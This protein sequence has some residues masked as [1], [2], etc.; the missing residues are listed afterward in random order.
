LV[1]PPSVDT[2]HFSLDI[3]KDVARARLNIPAGK[4]V[5]LFVGQFIQR[6]GVSTLIS[7]LARCVNADPSI[8]LVLVGSGIEKAAY[9]NLARRIGVLDHIVFPGTV[10]Y[11]NLPLF[12][13]SADLFVLPSFQ[14]GFGVVLVEALSAGTPIV[15]SRIDGI[16]DAVREGET[17]VLAEAGN[18]LDFAT[19]ILDLLR[20]HR[21]RDR[22]SQDGR[23]TAV[24]EYGLATFV[25][26]WD[27]AIRGLFTS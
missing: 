19:C 25:G 26:K 27:D 20:D 8:I 6:K 1:I 18:D 2:S 9:I 7:A 12:Y 10:E 11:A 5:I 3:P 16:K 4:K 13:R 24:R 21:L 15:A 17:S 23:E 14:E 22:L